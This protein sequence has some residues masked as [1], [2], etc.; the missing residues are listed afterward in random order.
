MPRTAVPI[1]ALTSE[2]QN[3]YVVAS[4]GVAIDPT[5]SHVINVPADCD[6]RELVLVVTNTT[7]STK[8]ATVKAGINP[9]A[10]RNGA[11]DLA[12][13]L[14]DGSTTPQNAMV[15][16]TGSRFVQ[17]D[18][19]INVDIAASMAGRITCLRIPRNA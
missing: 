6:P 10:P 12:V 8:V 11:G 15:P 4:A 17:S 2:T 14:T 19:T 5:N 13:S 1:T 9:P 7:A 16:L 3:A 18:G